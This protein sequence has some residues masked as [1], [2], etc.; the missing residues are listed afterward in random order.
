LENLD[1]DDDVDINRTW[2]NMREKMKAPAI[3][4]VGYYRVKQLKP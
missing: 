3:D 2:K 1:D 4:D